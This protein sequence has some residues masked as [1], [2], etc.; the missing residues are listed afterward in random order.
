MKSILQLSLLFQGWLRKSFQPADWKVVFLDVIK[1]FL[2]ARGVCC[3]QS[4]QLP[5]L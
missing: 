3:P 5:V 2:V 1:V 4:L